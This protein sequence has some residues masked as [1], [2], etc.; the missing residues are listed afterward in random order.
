M[1]ACVFRKDGW[2]GHES[3][4]KRQ[5]TLTGSLFYSI[6]CITTIGYGDQTPKTQVLSPQCFKPNSGIFLSL[7]WQASD[8][9]LRHLRH[10]SDVAVPGED[11]EGHGNLL[12]VWSAQSFRPTAHILFFYQVPLLA[13]LLL[14]VP[15]LEGKHL[16]SPKTTTAAGFTSLINKWDP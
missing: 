14:P 9:V 7:V 4:T 1:T 8:H 3:H 5:W 16:F 10:A 11:W 13:S 12:Q 6:I 2:N 15:H